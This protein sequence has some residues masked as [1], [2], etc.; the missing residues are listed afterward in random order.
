MLK[1]Y[2]EHIAGDTPSALAGLL[3]LYEVRL[4]SGR[5]RHILAMRDILPPVQE[6][7]QITRVIDIKGS[8]VGRVAANKSTV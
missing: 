3:G 8:L 1:S 2:S 5:R 7:G 6:R 4:S